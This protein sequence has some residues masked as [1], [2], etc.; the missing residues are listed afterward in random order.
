MVRL[1][2]GN[3]LVRVFL[4]GGYPWFSREDVSALL[5]ID[6]DNVGFS[7]VALERECREVQFEDRPPLTLVSQAGVDQLM[8]LNQE[9]SRVALNQRLSSWLAHNVPQALTRAGYRRGLLGWARRH[10]RN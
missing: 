5:E 4:I 3:R 1:Q 7:S 8:I 9:P 2:F 6:S 10:T